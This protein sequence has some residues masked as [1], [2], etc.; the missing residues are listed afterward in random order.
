[1][2]DPIK[3]ALIIA[4]AGMVAPTIS[5]ITAAIASKAAAREAHL[6]AE[7]ARETRYLVTELV[8]PIL[9]DKVEKSAPEEK[10]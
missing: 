1:M 8:A 10:L 3:I 2:N 6:A 9:K 7:H 5:A 4:V